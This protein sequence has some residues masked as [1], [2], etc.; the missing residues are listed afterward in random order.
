MLSDNGARQIS[1]N[2]VRISMRIRKQ[3]SNAEPA[4]ASYA[5]KAIGARVVVWERRHL[6][7]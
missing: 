5:L 6:A 3:T 4:F 2:K 7:C 1:G